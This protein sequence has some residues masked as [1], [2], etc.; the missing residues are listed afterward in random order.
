VPSPPPTGLRT[1]GSQGG[2]WLC[3]PHGSRRV[4]AQKVRSHLAVDY[5][6]GIGEFE[7]TIQI[8]VVEVEDVGD[9]WTGEVSN[10]HDV[11]VD[12]P[13]S[14]AIGCLDGEGNLRAVES[15]YTDRDDIEAGGSSTYAVR[16]GRDHPGCEALMAGSSGYED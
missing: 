9:E 14:V 12:G 4:R 7:N 5:T 6:E 1:T 11:D 16:K 10:P 2:E 3:W 13:V 15:S 8:D